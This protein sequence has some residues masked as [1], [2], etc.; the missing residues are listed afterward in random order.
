MDVGDWQNEAWTPTVFLT[1]KLVVKHGERY[2]HRVSVETFLTGVDIET[3]DAVISF[4]SP[5]QQ[6]LQINTKTCSIAVGVR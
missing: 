5:Q 3:E 6:N 2:F 4:R 1:P